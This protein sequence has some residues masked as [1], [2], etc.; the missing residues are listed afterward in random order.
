MNNFKYSI[1][2]YLQ[3]CQFRYFSQLIFI[4]NSMDKPK[5]K[6]LTFRLPKI[7]LEK[8]LALSILN[9]FLHIR[10]FG[11]HFKIDKFSSFRKLFWEE[12]GKALMAVFAKDVDFL[13]MKQKKQLKSEQNWGTIFFFFWIILDNFLKDMMIFKQNFW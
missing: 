11:A 12:L 4:F 6:K 3:H 8:N 10:F 2:N 9:S 1:K 13:D 5:Q 7:E